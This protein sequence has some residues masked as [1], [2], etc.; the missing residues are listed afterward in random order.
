MRTTV[1]KLTQDDWHGS[2]TLSDWYVGTK[3][4]DTKLV[5]V[6]FNG[7]ISPPNE[8]PMYR[9]C[10]WGNDDCGLEFDSYLEGEVWNKFLQVIGMEYVN[11]DSVISLGFVSA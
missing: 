4:G 9:T 6:T 7:N 11:M 5:T 8:A 3:P 10:V 1:F 2:Y